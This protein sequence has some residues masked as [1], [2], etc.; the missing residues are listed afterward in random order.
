MEDSETG[1]ELGER[2]HIKIPN[3]SRRAIDLYAIMDAWRLFDPGLWAGRRP[4]SSGTCSQVEVSLEEDDDSGE[5]EPARA[6]IPQGEE[7]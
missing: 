7:E 2:M 3:A 1:A 6:S 4:S 5:R